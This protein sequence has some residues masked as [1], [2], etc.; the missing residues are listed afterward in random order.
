MTVDSAST[1]M[2]KIMIIFM[3]S[4]SKM[5]HLADAASPMRF[6]GVTLNTLFVRTILT[7]LQVQDIPS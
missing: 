5:T 2:I 7:Q 4:T 3:S 1:A 6:V